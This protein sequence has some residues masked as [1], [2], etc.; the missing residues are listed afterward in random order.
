MTIDQ[1]ILNAI[2]AII[3]GGIAVP[4]IQWLKKQLKI[5]DGWKAMLLTLVEVSAVTAGYLLYVT[6]TF[7]WPALLGY[8]IYAFIQASG[9]FTVTVNKKPA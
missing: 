5:N 8:A 4:I 9:I 6:H 7:T 1:G 3:T 2:L